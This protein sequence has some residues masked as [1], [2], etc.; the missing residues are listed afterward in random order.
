MLVGFGWEVKDWNN[1]GLS[2]LIFLSIGWYLKSLGV[3]SPCF[4]EN[5]TFIWHISFQT[6]LPITKSILLTNNFYR[7]PG[8]CENQT[9]ISLFCI[10]LQS[11]F[12]KKLAQPSNLLHQLVPSTIFSAISGK[13][14]EFWSSN[15]CT[16]TQHSGYICCQQKTWKPVEIYSFIMKFYFSSHLDNSPSILKL[17]TWN[18]RISRSKNHENT[19]N[20]RET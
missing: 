10:L 8:P 6:N 7:I 4:P 16:H 18:F 19:Q 2:D 15:Q 9:Q 12:L 3:Y 17:A 11:T 20:L 13:V 14:N 5:Q 1:T